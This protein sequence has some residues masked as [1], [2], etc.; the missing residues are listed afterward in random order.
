MKSTENY[1]QLL[2]RFTKR[3]A[4]I[5]AKKDETQIKSPQ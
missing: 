1:E 4:Q 2:E 3:N 5:K